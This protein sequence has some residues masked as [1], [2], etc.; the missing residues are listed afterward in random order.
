MSESN[1]D[2]KE[3]MEEAVVEKVTKAKKTTKATEAKKLQN[4]RK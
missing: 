4:P 1:S 3:V 2:N